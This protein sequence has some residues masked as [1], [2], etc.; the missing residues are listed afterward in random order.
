MIYLTF[1]NM[2]IHLSLL[3]NSGY[4]PGLMN[5]NSKVI[6]SES[7]YM[8]LSGMLGNW[9]VRF[10]PKTMRSYEYSV[11]LHG[12]LPVLEYDAVWLKNPCSDI[13][14]FRRECRALIYMTLTLAFSKSRGSRL[15]SRASGNQ[16]VSAYDTTQYNRFCRDFYW[17]MYFPTMKPSKRSNIVGLYPFLLAY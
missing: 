12:Q 10:V 3:A 7:P 6:G 16:Y 13:L 1:H 9:T 17:N 5:R 15:A 4:L 8:I 14:P 11:L 2:Q